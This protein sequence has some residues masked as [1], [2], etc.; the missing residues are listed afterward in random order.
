MNKCL[1]NEDDLRSLILFSR[2]NG[3]HALDEYAKKQD[4][5]MIMEM[6]IK[7]AHLL[8]IADVGT[9]KKYGKR[10]DVNREEFEQERKKFRK[11]PSL[12][13][14]YI[15]QTDNYVYFRNTIG[16]GNYPIVQTKERIHIIFNYPLKH[17]KEGKIETDESRLNGR[18]LGHSAVDSGTQVIIDPFNVAIKK[19]IRPDL[20]CIVDVS[21]RKYKC[22]FNGARNFLS[23][24]PAKKD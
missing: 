8:K 11:E 3:G 14:P 9:I 15:A 23:I 17:S 22:K 21:K 5:L 18:L 6:K 4:R 10:L 16:D 12:N 19:S 2:E 1:S 20:Y 24:S 7:F 13:P